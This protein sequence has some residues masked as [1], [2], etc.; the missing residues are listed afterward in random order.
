MVV[1]LG[2]ACDSAPSSDDLCAHVR[3]LCTPEQRCR[4]ELEWKAMRQALGD[5]VVDGHRT[6]LWNSKG[7]ADVGDCDSDPV[8]KRWTSQ[9]RD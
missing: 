7:C 3:T 8:I 4:S 2:S 9:R 6:C 5:R 1:A